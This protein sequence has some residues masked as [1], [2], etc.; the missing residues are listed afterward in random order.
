MLLSGDSG[1]AL[2]VWAPNG[3]YKCVVPK[4]E[5]WDRAP[6]FLLFRNIRHDSEGTT[7][8]A[9]C[10]H[11]LAPTILIDN[12]Y[13]PF[14]RLALLK[15]MHFHLK[16]LLNQICNQRIT[17][18]GQGLSITSHS[19]ISLEINAFHRSSLISFSHQFSRY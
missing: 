16:S 5:F 19:P 18:S 15:A 7:E 3:E 12:N 11:T 17:M 14:G 6:Q 2:L 10:D 13:R 8:T 4:Y 9:I 1:H